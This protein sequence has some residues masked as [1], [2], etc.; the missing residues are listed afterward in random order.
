MTATLAAPVRQDRFV[1]K[2]CNIF[3]RPYGH[4]GA[5]W[6]AE[7]DRSSRLFNREA[8]LGT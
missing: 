2:V 4:F 6:Q 3:T 7:I 8:Q 5:V 1:G